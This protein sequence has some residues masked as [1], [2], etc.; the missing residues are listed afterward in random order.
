MWDLYF[1][2]LTFVAA[3]RENR[4]SGALWED[5]YEL[6]ESLISDTRCV[7]GNRRKKNEDDDLNAIR[8]VAVKVA[9]YYAKGRLSDSLHNMMILSDG[10]EFAKDYVKFLA[11]L[12]KK[13]KA[14][15]A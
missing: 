4:L 3:P 10:C 2:L 14:V 9:R 1:E 5:L 11:R 12:E 15:K 6:R 13:S 8:R 7:F